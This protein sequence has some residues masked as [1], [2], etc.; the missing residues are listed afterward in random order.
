L[1]VCGGTVV[2][3]K[4]GGGGGSG[5]GGRF[6]QLS[7]ALETGG[8]GNGGGKGG[9]IPKVH[10]CGGPNVAGQETSAGGGML[11]FGTRGGG[12]LTKLDD[13]WVDCG[14]GGGI[15]LGGVSPGGGGTDGSRGGGKTYG[16]IGT[17]ELGGTKL[18]GNV[19][20]VVNR[21]GVRVRGL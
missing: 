2:E 3:G 13:D 10:G 7:R 5:G 8:G 6:Q 12:K 1:S 19:G 21:R 9:N 20:G 4:G 11:G 15:N 18:G 17:E 14:R 16:P